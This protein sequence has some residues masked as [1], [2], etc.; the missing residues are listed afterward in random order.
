MFVH[1]Q[2]FARAQEKA[3]VGL[4]PGALNGVYK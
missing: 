1:E 3:R 4:R 2:M